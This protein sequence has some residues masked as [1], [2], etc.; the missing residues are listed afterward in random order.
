MRVEM[1]G[2]LF[3]LNDEEIAACKDIIKK[4][5]DER[6]KKEVFEENREWLRSAVS[7]IID[8]IG[9]EDT[10]RI[11]REINQDLRRKGE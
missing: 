6:H 8:A 1:D 3:D 9:I 11:L 7:A 5:R 10:K 4:M 2:Y